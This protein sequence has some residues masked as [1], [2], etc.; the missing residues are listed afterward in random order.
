MEF[1]LGSVASIEMEQKKF[2]LKAMMSAIAIKK[3]ILKIDSN[4]TSEQ[5]AFW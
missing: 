4:V 2:T 1:F 5:V 3:L